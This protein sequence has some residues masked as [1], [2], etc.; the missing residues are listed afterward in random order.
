MVEAMA[1]QL[2]AVRS[3]RRV[4]TRWVH[5]LIEQREE[6]KTRFSRGYDFQRALCEDP[7]ALRAWFWLVANMKAKYGILD[8]DTY[9]CDETAFAI[10]VIGGTIVVT[11]SER[12]GQRKKVQPGNKE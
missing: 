11:G 7:N 5:R 10:G 4:G 2:L 12:Q 1:N 9:N 8:C 3:S 6:L